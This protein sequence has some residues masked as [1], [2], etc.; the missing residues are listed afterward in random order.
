VGEALFSLQLPWKSAAAKKQSVIEPVHFSDAWLGWCFGHTKSPMPLT[1]W[2]Q[3][4]K[5]A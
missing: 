3:S 2:T 5:M 1:V 4:S